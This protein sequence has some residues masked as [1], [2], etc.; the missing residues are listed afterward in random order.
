MKK[1]VAAVIAV[2]SLFSTVVLASPAQAVS[3]PCSDGGSFNVVDNVVTGHNSC[4][5][6]LVIPASVTRVADY[7]FYVYDGSLTSVTFEAGSQLTSLGNYAFYY[8]SLDS[9]VLPEG[10]REIGDKA[11]YFTTLSSIT[12]PSTVT[13]IGFHAFYYSGTL[14]SVTFAAPSQLTTIG[15]WAFAYQNLSSVSLPASLTNV[16]AGAFRYNGNLSNVTFAGNA[17]TMGDGAGIFD[18][19][20]GGATATVGS[21]ATGFGNNGDS[22]YGLTVTKPAALLAGNIPEFG[23]VTS[24][25]DG[26]SVNIT[27][28]DSA[29]AYSVSAS[30]GTATI[31]PSG[32]VVVTGVSANTEIEV[33][34]STDRRGYISGEGTVSGRSLAAL[35]TPLYP[36][37]FAQTATS[38]F[39][40]WGSVDGATGYTVTASNGGGTCT[41]TINYCTITG[42][43]TG[44]SYTFNIVANRAGQSSSPAITSSVTMTSPLDVGGS[45]SSSTWKVGATVTANPLIIG[46]YSILRHQW[47]RCAA[48]VAVQEAAPACDA[49]AGAT[50]GTYT[51]TAADLG[52]YVTSHMTVTGGAGVVTSTLANNR[53]VLAANA[54]GGALVDPDGKPLIAEIP[55]RQISVVG[56]TTITITGTGFT[57]VTSVLVNGTAATVLS[58]TDTTLVISVPASTQVGLVDL[59]VTTPKGTV[60]EASALAYVAKQA[61]I[62]SKKKT[63]TGFS[64][65]VTKLSTKQK[66]EIKAFVKANSTMPKLTCA[67]STVGVKKSSTE[68]KAALARA[69][70]ACSY[71]ASVSKNVFTSSNGAQGKTSGKVS[72]LVTLTISN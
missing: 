32:R 5:G 1:L 68:A 19:V 11:F 70:A 29:F 20:A 21:T 44:Q 9:I 59:A 7:A 55:T 35:A 69:K 63:L 31:S 15:D 8:S 10:L 50:G 40:T 26:M 43:T 71:A 13:Y 62:S 48:V 58:A 12:I 64:G 14:T 57:G 60:T 41:N 33:S 23:A 67:A 38:A 37:A 27:N 25:S 28:F 42:L 65:S 53:A 45:L 36:S 17:P 56:G 51:L 61:S 46:Q 72:K 3:Y 66:A 34:V 6:S 30:P 22:W 24:T 54:A 2:L 18:G 39:V 49:I 52:K 4:K 47:Y 16:G